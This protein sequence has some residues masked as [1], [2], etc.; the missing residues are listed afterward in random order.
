MNDR[1][2]PVVDVSQWKEPAARAAV[3]Q[4]FDD[5]CCRFGFLNITGTEFRTSS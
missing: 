4:A 3:A 1:S 5:A 2:I